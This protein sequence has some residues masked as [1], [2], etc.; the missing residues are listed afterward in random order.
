M[1]NRILWIDNAR[2]ISLLCVIA[3]HTGFV[4]PWLTKAY[5]P[6][7][8]T[9]FFF[10]SG[11][12]FY[13]PNKHY[14]ISQKAL[15]I[16]TSLIIPYCTYCFL[17]SIYNLFVGGSEEFVSDILISLLGIKSWFISALVVIELLGL[18]ILWASNRYGRV[19]NFICPFLFLIIYFILPDLEYYV[20]NLKNAMF[21]GL[22]FSLGMICRDYNIS[23]H[24][25]SNKV[26]L[27]LMI[28]YICLVSADIHWNLN[29]GNFNESF[30]NYPFFIIESLFGIPAFIWLCSKI[31]RY[32]KLI[33]FIGSNSLLYYYLQSAT[34]RGIWAFINRL[35]INFP[36]FVEFIIIVMGVSIVISIPVIFINKY[37]PI[38]SGKYRI[39]IND[40]RK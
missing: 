5:L 37:F 30:T 35:N 32:N 11:F 36:Q 23:S 12:L 40:L 4:E 26:G 10:I 24:F 8:L 27:P 1:K 21:A 2:G 25:L 29:S 31:R 7:F 33:L 9:A 28:I 39:K 17:T 18:C 15:N 19:I 6:I 34:I 38:F 13:A 16:F 22:Y 20:W 3:H 14:S